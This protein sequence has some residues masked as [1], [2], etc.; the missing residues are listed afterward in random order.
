MTKATDIST[1]SGFFTDRLLVAMPTIV[2]PQFSRS[3]VYVC[4][5]NEDGAMGLVVNKPMPDISFPELLVQLEIE[6]TSE[7][8]TDRVNFGGPVETGRGFVLHSSEFQREGTMVVSQSVAL[9][10][11]LDILKAIAEGNGPKRHLL[12]LGYACWDAGQLDDEV[13]QNGWLHAPPD[14]EILFGGELDSKWSRAIGKLG[15]DP[16]R[17]S[18]LTGSA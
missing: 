12:A 16:S 8:L 10:A 6:L 17:L 2:D 4:A 7:I 13:R 5:H 18:S 1:D 14:D 15:F 3:V 9:T 11:T